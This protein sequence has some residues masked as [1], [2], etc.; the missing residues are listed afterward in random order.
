MSETD[1][2]SK[3]GVEGFRLL[4]ATLVRELEKVPY[5]H[6]EPNVDVLCREAAY[7]I[8]RLSVGID[9]LAAELDRHAIALPPSVE[10]VVAR[11]REAPH[12][13]ASTR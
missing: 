2:V 1:D 13:G 7:A 3:L 12:D 5:I 9:A 11:A 6:S 4:T 8:T 10:R